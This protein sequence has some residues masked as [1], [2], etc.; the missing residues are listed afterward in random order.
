MSTLKTN[1]AIGMVREP[2]DDL[3]FTFVTPLGAY[4]NNV[5]CHGSSG[6]IELI[7]ATRIPEHH[8]SPPDIADSISK[9][10]VR[11][12]FFRRAQVHD[13]IGFRGHHF[14]EGR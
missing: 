13:R 14:Q 9:G 3:A 12:I 5:F 1:D 11:P 8:A 2:V 4:Y 7:A 10:F 6:N